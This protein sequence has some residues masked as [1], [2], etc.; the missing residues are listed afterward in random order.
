MKSLSIEPLFQRS[1][2]ARVLDQGPVPEPARP[3]HPAITIQETAMAFLRC[4]LQPS[5]YGPDEHARIKV[6]DR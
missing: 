6:P 1:K 3:R 2:Q 4:E 5:H